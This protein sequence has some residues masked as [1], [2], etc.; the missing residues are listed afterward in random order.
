MSRTDAAFLGLLED[1]PSR[2]LSIFDSGS[3]STLTSAGF[4]ADSRKK[5]SYFSSSRTSYRPSVSEKARPPFRLPR[6][7]R[8]PTSILYNRI[9]LVSN[10]SPDPPT[11]STYEVVNCCNFNGQIKSF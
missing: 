2:K 1:T 4:G 6:L 5:M 9:K 8:S 3:D 10:L 11:N 7:L